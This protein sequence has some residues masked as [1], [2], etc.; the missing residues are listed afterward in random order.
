MMAD[1]MQEK[2]GTPKGWREDNIKALQE[3]AEV[4]V[5]KE[6]F[7]RLLAESK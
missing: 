5:F 3:M 6:E 7:N 4:Q 1:Y 2:F